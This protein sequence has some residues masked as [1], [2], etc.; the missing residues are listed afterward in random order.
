ML[1]LKLKNDQCLIPSNYESGAACFLVLLKTYHK[2]LQS[3]KGK[4]SVFRFSNCAEF[5]LP[6]RQHSW[7]TVSQILKWYKRFYIKAHTLETLLSDIERKWIHNLTKTL[8]VLWIPSQFSPLTIHI[9]IELLLT[10]VWWS[11]KKKVNRRKI[12]FGR[13]SNL[14][15]YTIKDRGYWSSVH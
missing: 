10:L 4:R 6:S 9:Q 7:K 14:G 13:W 8:Q 15:S 2:M 11:E 3:L 12:V 1:K 5:W